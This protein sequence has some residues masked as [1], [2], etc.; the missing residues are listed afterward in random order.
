MERREKLGHLHAL[1]HGSVKE[2]FIGY[3]PLRSSLR[4]L[5]FRD[6]HGH[7]F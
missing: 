1:R 2:K 4:V 5:E 7:E 6:L 3:L